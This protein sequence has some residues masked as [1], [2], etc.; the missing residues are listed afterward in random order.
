MKTLEQIIN[1]HQQSEENELNFR[2]SSDYGQISTKQSASP[3]NRMNAY[4]IISGLGEI[5]KTD[6]GTYKLFE[7]LDNWSASGDESKA[8]HFE[9]ALTALNQG[10]DLQSVSNG[11]Q[12][13]WDTNGMSYFI[14]DIVRIARAEGINYQGKEV[15]EQNLDSEMQIY[16][17]LIN[18]YEE[19]LQKRP[20]DKEIQDSLN[21][22][23]YRKK[24]EEDFFQ[25]NK[26][27]NQ[28]TL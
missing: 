28:T 27:A 11:L 4:K 21:E 23:K 1:E 18:S 6:Y 15:Y 14:R 5:V 20:N 2:L 24:I 13:I 3:M 26:V 10:K 22:L 9:Y 8:R 7:I 17:Y 25:K 19:K 16:E 12:Q